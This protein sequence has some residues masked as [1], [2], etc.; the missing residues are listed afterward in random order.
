VAAH[1][2]YKHC[3]ICG[4][5]LKMIQRTGDLRPVCPDCDHTVYYDPKVAV[6]MLVLRGDSVLLV[7]RGVDPEKGKWALPA[8]FVN[9][10][11]AP[12]DAAV[13]EIHEEADIT[14]LN[15][16]LLDVFA[17]PGDGT[18]DIIIAYGGIAATDDRAQAADD[19]EEA[20][21]F[22]REDLPP[23][24]FKTTEWLIGRLQRGEITLNN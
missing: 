8:G 4:V 23:T 24:A 21:F 1:K 9:A 11:E 12:A 17:N 13:R 16:R 20:T 14:L 2:A 19:A 3:P 15:I 6:V 5:A 22:H 10:G 18:A 7:K